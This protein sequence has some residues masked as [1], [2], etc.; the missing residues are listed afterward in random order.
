[1]G[2]GGGGRAE[3]CVLFR[4]D[5][6]LNYAMCR[7][8]NKFKCQ[9]CANCILPLLRMQFRF[10]HIRTGTA[11]PRGCLLPHSDEIPEHWCFALIWHSLEASVVSC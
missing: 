6:L 8:L 1:M 9:L 11:G 3:V 7:V 5:C 4:Q 10:D 2:R